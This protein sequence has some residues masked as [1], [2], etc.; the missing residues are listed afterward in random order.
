M[1]ETLST[2]A[3][4]IQKQDYDDFSAFHNFRTYRK[5]LPRLVRWPVYA[6]LL[7]CAAWFLWHRYD[8]F[9]VEAFRRTLVVVLLM[10]L[11]AAIAG[12]FMH[13]LREQA[14]KGSAFTHQNVV[15]LAPDTVVRCNAVGR[16]SHPWSSVFKVGD[17]GRV[18]LIYVSPKAAI[19]IPKR[20]FPSQADAQVFFDRATELRDLALHPHVDVF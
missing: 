14:T 19:I 11:V 17:A 15:T 13:R 10:V 3:F 5:P 1:T 2:P 6:M 20:I 16:S 12:F 4:V 18:I 9:G 8:A 7:A